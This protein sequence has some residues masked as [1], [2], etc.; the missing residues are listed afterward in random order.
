[1]AK[2]L[3]AG[4]GRRLRLSK[5]ARQRAAERGLSVWAMEKALAS[6]MTDRRGNNLL[7]YDLRSAVGVLVDWQSGRVVTAMRLEGAEYAGLRARAER[8]GYVLVGAGSHET[9]DGDRDGG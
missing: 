2:M 8:D 4:F 7:H 9:A 5:H 3:R 6:G 1:M